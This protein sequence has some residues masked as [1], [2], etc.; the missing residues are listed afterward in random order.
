VARGKLQGIAGEFAYALSIGENPF[1]RHGEARCALVNKRGVGASKSIARSH[2]GSVLRPRAMPSQLQ[3]LSGQGA[4]L[5]AG[6]TISGTRRTSTRRALNISI[7]SA[8][9]PL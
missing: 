5:Q 1:A 6:R 3:S 8:R 4:S 9:P 2:A 7:S